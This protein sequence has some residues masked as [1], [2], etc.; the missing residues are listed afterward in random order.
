MQIAAM[1]ALYISRDDIPESV[2]AYQVDIF[3][4]QLKEEG[5]PEKAWPKIVE[6]KLDK[7]KAEV[8]LLEQES[9]AHPKTTIEQLRTSLVAKMGENVKVRRFVRWELGEGLSKEKEDFATEIAKL[10][11]G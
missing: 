7:W 10:T 2:R 11:N 3:T 5:K 4:A 1:G 9:I 6:G 8:C